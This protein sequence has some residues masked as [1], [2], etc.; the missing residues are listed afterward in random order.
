MPGA[1]G[2]Q[3]PTA[4][5]QIAFVGLGRMGLPMCAAL[6][7]ADHQ[8]VATD[9]RA[10]SRADALAC[11]AD[12]RDTP[13]Q[14]AATADVLITVLPGPRE[15]QAAMLGTAGALTGLAAGTT[16]IDMT[17]NSPAAVRPIREQATE[18]GV[19]VLEAPAGGGIGAAR[20]GR[21]QLFVGGDPGVVERHRRLLEVLGD[22]ERVVHVGGHGA[23]YTV[24]LLV[25]L[26]WFG[27]AVATAEAL[28]LGQRAGIDLRVLE[29]A[30]SGS[31][32]ASAFI[33]RDVDLL[34]RGDYLPSFGLDRIC[35][36]LEAVTVL[37]HDCQVPFELSDLVC[38]TYR[39]A[40]ARYGPLDGERGCPGPSGLRILIG[41]SPERT[42]S[43][44]RE[45]PQIHS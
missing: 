7:R 8:V 22:P 32:A 23:G 27:Q 33:S 26:L 13:A 21:L 24:K 45:I 14:A 36:E 6:A 1:R 19:E 42:G 28:L 40:L 2:N 3:P 30:L 12:W 10:E 18:R 29:H 31:S 43:R 44:G 17:S 5:P 39:R 11:G 15:V 9:K 38:R 34:F 41:S 16:W 4:L 35:E 37:A 25:N 20:E